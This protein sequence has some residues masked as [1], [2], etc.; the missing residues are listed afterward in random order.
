[1]RHLR[2]ALALVAVLGM[3]G[4]LV[5]AA[6]ARPDER[7]AGDVTAYVADL[8][9]AA[10]LATQAADATEWLAA[11]DAK[12]CAQV[13]PAASRL[14]A[15]AAAARDVF[16]RYQR[17]KT[18][19]GTQ[20]EINLLGVVAL[21]LRESRA[22]LR[23]V[24]GEASGPPSAAEQASARKEVGI[25][26]QFIAI[27]LEDRFR[28]EG[29]ADVLTATSF[30]DFTRRATAELHRRLKARGE[31]ELRR[32]TGL[33]IRLDVPIGRQ[34]RDFLEAELSRALSK[35]VVAAGPAGIFVN[36]V[37]GRFLDPGRIVAL[38]GKE[39]REALRNKGNLE[40]R[41][42]A[43]IAGLD[44]LRRPLNAP[45]DTPVD[46]I[47]A[48][49]RNAQRALGQTAFLK[50]DLQRA[51]DSTN[52]PG[53]KQTLAQLLADLKKKEGD[54]A[55]AIKLA[56]GRFFLDSQLVGEDW[57]I[58]ISYATKTLAEAERLAKK[59]GC[60]ISL[61]KPPTSSPPATNGMPTAAVCK[62][63]TIRMEYFSSLGAKLG[64]YIAVFGKLVKTA[65]F[66]HKC[67]W[68]VEGSTTSEAFVVFIDRTPLGT[69][70]SVPAGNCAGNRPDSHP[71]YNSRKRQLGVSGGER[72]AFQRAL[73]GNATILKGVLAAAEA[74][75]V[76]KSCP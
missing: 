46:R 3:G 73:A 14:A 27:K 39:L 36:L 34:I 75:G 35:L 61:P 9:E 65:T 16:R 55:R 18:R 15:A 23:K 45:K 20:E 4:L 5:T 13:S 74:A 53:R 44:T 57:S 25:F 69:P 8:R 51:I 70:G 64:E 56:T 22:S 50:G 24:A 32:L 58:G 21:G 49:V 68:Y 62:P 76:G 66:G 31:A 41:T 30:R 47:R 10:Q 43:S 2:H 60:T 19:F 42:R 1:M 40:A 17:A 38:V 12:R 59:L 33:R 28:V 52:D 37:A 71:F 72:Q 7:P 29:L 63:A 48:A 6:S 26:Q 67:L 54:L 11:N